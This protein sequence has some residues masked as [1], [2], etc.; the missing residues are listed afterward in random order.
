MDRAP[1]LFLGTNAHALAAD[2]GGFAA[3]CIEMPVE[4]IWVICAGAV[5][6]RLVDVTRSVN[7]ERANE[8]A[9]RGR[10]PLP[11]PFRYRVIPRHP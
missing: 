8:A 7:A 3:S 1:Q 5:A 10:G 6:T 11:G 9:R 4:Q 2:L